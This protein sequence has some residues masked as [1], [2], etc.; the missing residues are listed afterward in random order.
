[1]LKKVLTLLLIS[2]FFI[3]GTKGSHLLGTD[4]S[5]V[6]DTSNQYTFT[7]NVYRDCQGTSL[8]SIAGTISCGSNSFKFTPTKISIQD[9]STVCDQY[10]TNCDTGSSSYL[11]VEKHTYKYTIDFDKAPYSTWRTNGCCNFIFSWSQY[12]RNGR[13]TTGQANKAM[14]A[15]CSINLCNIYKTRIQ[16]NN[17]P[18]LTP[19]STTLLICNKPVRINYGGKD[20]KEF[21][22]LSYNLIYARS[23]VTNTLPP[24][25]GMTYPMT[26]RCPITTQTNCKAYP[27]TNPP[28]GFYLDQYNGDLVFTPAKCDEVGVVVVQIQEWRRDS[29]GKALLV[30]TTMRDIE[31]TVINASSQNIPPEI[32]SGKYYY[33]VCEGDS[34]DFTFFGKDDTVSGYAPDTVS[35]A[36]DNTIPNATFSI[37]DTNSREKEVTF[38]WRTKIGDANNGVYSFAVVA[39]DGNCPYEAS[40]SKRFT[41][42]VLPKSKGEIRTKPFRNNLEFDVELDANFAGPASYIWQVYDSI[43]LTT[44]IHITAN[45]KDTIQFNKLGHFYFKLNLNNAYNC[46]NIVTDTFVLRSDT[47]LSPRIT[48]KDTHF[49]ICAGEKIDFSIFA[50][51][52]S[53]Q[54][55]NRLDTLELFLIDSNILGSTFYLVD[56]SARDKEGRFTWQTSLSDARDSVYS[57][58]AISVDDFSPFRDTT[59]QVFTIR[60]NP[61]PY[62]QINFE[63][64]CDHF[65]YEATLPNKFKFPAQ[66]LWK[67]E[68]GNTLFDSSTLSRDSLHSK[69]DTSYKATL[70][71]TN[72]F[73]CKDTFTSSFNSNKSPG[74]NAKINLSNTCT[75]VLYDATLKNSFN[76]PA[77]YKWFVQ[78]NTNLVDSSGNGIDSF[79][80][81]NDSNYLIT[82]I[83]KNKFSCVDTLEET[84]TINNG[85]NFPPSITSLKDHYEI[86]VNDSLRFL[87]NVVEKVNTLDTIKLDWNSISGSVIQVNRKNPGDKTLKFNWVPKSTDARDS[88][89]KLNIIAHDNACP[90]QDTSNKTITIKVNALPKANRKFHEFCGEKGMVFESILD[91]T[92]KPTVIY[93]WSITDS[94]KNI[95]H[96][97]QLPV[98]TF[99][100]SKLGRH[101]ITLNI[102]DGNKCKNTFTDTVNLRYVP[103]ILDLGKD[104]SITDR[105]SLLLKSNTHFTEYLWSTGSMDS[106]IQ[107]IGR[108][109]DTGKHL[110]WLLAKDSLGC[111]Y[112]DTIN[113]IVTSTVSIKALANANIVFYPSPVSDVL[114]IELRDEMNDGTVSLYNLQGIMLKEIVFNKTRNKLL[115]VNVSHLPKGIYLLKIKTKENEYVSKLIKD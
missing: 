18:V 1:M 47:N 103:S 10:N 84:I 100:A 20:H 45:K 70:I 11:G 4:L 66:Y 46:P 23:S 28:F 14:Y 114:K 34:I 106:M 6:H 25:I 29:S 55:V 49:S 64:T 56:S 93:N 13:I 31:L 69:Q 95:L 83:V 102:E 72:K 108:D 99:R 78:E 74:T 41:I 89:Y 7:V 87:V 21:D 37:K 54:S 51:D 113:I 92:V 88:L 43:D 94:A 85:T 12:S 15:D 42:K 79:A 22:S 104:T 3:Q 110:Y 44:P 82:L 5:Y 115:E 111:S 112:G 58:I 62:A 68:K 76:G 59:Y 33:T 63:E 48:S 60:V 77:S 75:H 27:N 35:L 39:K 86:C 71:I 40:S 8:D 91:S 17:S 81:Q 26:P 32:N 61:I 9:I 19:L 98:D 38:A 24:I 30:G 101:I 107:I 53:V 97:S 57:F 80:Y 96:T 73:L 50:K 52:S 109:I 65:I 36:W 90:K 2:L 67:I 105:D 16:H